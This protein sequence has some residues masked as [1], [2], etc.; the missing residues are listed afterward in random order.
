MIKPRSDC[1]AEALSDAELIADSWASDMPLRKKPNEDSH[2]ASQVNEIS[3]TKFLTCCTSKNCADHNFT[4]PND[5]R[6]SAEL[7]EFT[8]RIE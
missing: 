6:L 3:S 4:L 7:Q 1:C 2:L 8:R 5:K